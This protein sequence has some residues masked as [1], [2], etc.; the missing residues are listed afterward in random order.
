MSELRVSDEQTDRQTIP[1]FVIRFNYAVIMLLNQL[2]T[3]SP[4]VLYY[5]GVLF[6]YSKIV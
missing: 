1:S 4:N 2:W 3:S 6:Q 5:V